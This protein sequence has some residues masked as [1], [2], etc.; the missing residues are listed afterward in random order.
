MNHRYMMIIPTI[1]LEATEV[2]MIQVEYWE[3]NEVV[4]LPT[5]TLWIPTVNAH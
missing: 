1:V 2:G 3:A 4:L 5:L